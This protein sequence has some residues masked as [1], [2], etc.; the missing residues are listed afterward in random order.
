MACTHP[1]VE[2]CMEARRRV[3][4]ESEVPAWR[5]SKLRTVSAEATF[6]PAPGE[7]AVAA[8]TA[9]DRA[10]TGLRG[11]FW[12]KPNT[13]PAAKLSPHPTVSCTD[14][15]NHHSPGYPMLCILSN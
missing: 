8:P 9:F 6:L 1:I 7:V 15:C 14:T 12:M 5:E 11:C 2:T 3:P 4:L 10:S 13:I